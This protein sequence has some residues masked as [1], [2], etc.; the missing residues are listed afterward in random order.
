MQ[1]HWIVWPLHIC[2]RIPLHCT[3]V[4]LPARPQERSDFLTMNCA[5]GGSD[6]VGVSSI[7]GGCFDISFAGGRAHAAGL[8]GVAARLTGMFSQQSL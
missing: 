1:V 3:P 7:K 2:L 8:A 4:H 5:G 6:M